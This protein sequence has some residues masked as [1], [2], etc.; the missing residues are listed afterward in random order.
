MSVLDGRAGKLLFQKMRLFLLVPL[1]PQ[2]KHETKCLQQ[3]KGNPIYERYV[4]SR[5]FGEWLNGLCS[6]DPCQRTW[7]NGD[8]DRGAY[9]RWYLCQPGLPAIQEPDRSGPPDL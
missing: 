9:P 7:Q 6:R 4:R 8:Y 1:V 5:H 2:Q 3:E